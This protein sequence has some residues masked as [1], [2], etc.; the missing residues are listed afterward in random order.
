[1]D[2]ELGFTSIDAVAASA[3]GLLAVADRGSC[4]IVVFSVNRPGPVRRLSRCGGGPSELRQVAGLAFRGDT[5]AAYDPTKQA[6]LFFDLE[7]NELRRFAPA[8]LTEAGTPFGLMGLENVNDTLMAVG[9]LLPPGSASHESQLLALIDARNGATV[10]RFLGDPEI[11]QR[12]PDNAIRSARFCIAHIDGRAYLAAI[13]NW[14]FEGVVFSLPELEVVGHFVTDVPWT[15]PKHVAR[16]PAGVL[17]PGPRYATVGCTS[18]GFL[19]RQ[20]RVDE[21]NKPVRILGGLMEWR[22]LHGQ[23]LSSRALAP[24]DSLLQGLA[25]AGSVNAVYF[26]TRD[27]DGGW[28]VIREIVTTGSMDKIDNDKIDNPADSGQRARG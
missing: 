28:P 16:D 6:V 2:G 17:R 27:R 18:R 12:N 25:E 19:F 22:D 7:G 13:N 20:H 11:S 23:R 3:S 5:I 10:R 9:L 21:T 24:D 4:Q 26:V 1:M 14:A 15:R 8:L